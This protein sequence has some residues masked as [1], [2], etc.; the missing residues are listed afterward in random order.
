MVPEGSYAMRRWAA[1]WRAHGLQQR[2]EE[3]SRRRVAAARIAIAVRR[4]LAERQRRCQEAEAS[5]ERDAAFTASLA[6]D[7]LA[8]ARGM[9]G[10]RQ[11][12]ARRRALQQLEADL[13]EQGLRIRSGLGN[14]GRQRERRRRRLERQAVS[15]GVD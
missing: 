5:L 12:L 13:R 14:N 8:H 15:G 2:E 7:E 9:C 10:V 3:A 1:A 11:Y 6:D 4:W